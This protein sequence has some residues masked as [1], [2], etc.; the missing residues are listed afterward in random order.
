[1]K[2]FWILT[3]LIASLWATPMQAQFEDLEDGPNKERVEALRV[4]F[5]TQK[6]KLTTEESKTF[7]PVYEEFQQEMELL[8][9]EHRSVRK[10]LEIKFK[11][12]T[13]EELET[14]MEEFI[15]FQFE[16]A[17]IIATY[18]DEFLKVLPIRKVALLYKAEQDFKREL[19][20]E[21]RN[22]SMRPNGPPMGR[23]PRT[24]P[25]GPGTG[26]RGGGLRP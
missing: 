8:R 7:W 9:E 11:R 24:G 10:K 18:H 21:I 26:P 23:S 12:A 15:S 5:I 25:G 6:L 3:G 17:K 4:A 13:D 19:I 2:N 20:K 14:L 22:R 16:E 1:M